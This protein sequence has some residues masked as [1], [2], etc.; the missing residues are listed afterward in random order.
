MDGSHDLATCQA[1]CERVLSAVYHQLH[2]HGVYLEGTLLKPSMCLAGADSASGPASEQAVAEATV[3]CLRRTVPSSVPGVVFLSGGMSEQQATANLHAIN[4]ANKGCGWKLSF[5]YG[6]A[7]Q[8]SVLKAWQGK[9][10]NVKS[11]QGVFL[12]LAKQNSLAAQGI[13]ASASKSAS[14]E[15]TFERNYTY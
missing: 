3:T 13:V 8:G 12:A 4:V 6:R 2:C 15:G 9:S 10:E 7:L 14:S 1:V 5:S 11:A